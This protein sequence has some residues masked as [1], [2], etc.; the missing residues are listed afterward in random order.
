[1][2]GS[3]CFPAHLFECKLGVF[4]QIF[5]SVFDTKLRLRLNL[6]RYAVELMIAGHYA[7]ATVDSADLPVI[8]GQHGL[9]V[10]CYA[11]YCARMSP[12]SPL[13]VD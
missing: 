1:M 11:N 8:A 7:D 2:S 13:P 10:H 6:R 3:S 5:N 4:V 9:G 12:M